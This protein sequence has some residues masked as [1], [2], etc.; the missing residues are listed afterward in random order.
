[1]RCLWV[2]DTGCRSCVLKDQPSQYLWNAYCGH[3][4]NFG[5]NVTSANREGKF[6][7]SC[8]LS[9]P[10]AGPRRTD[11]PPKDGTEILGEWAIGKRYASWGVY[12]DPCFPNRAPQ[13]WLANGIHYITNEKPIWWAEILPQE[14]GS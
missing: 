5:V 1:M 3:P 10:V 7:N 14:E 2:G 6:D 12:C 11:E 9:T 4:E 8:P 13:A